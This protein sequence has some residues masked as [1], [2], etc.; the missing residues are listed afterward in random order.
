LHLV[1]KDG[2]FSISPSNEYSGLIS[3]T[4][5]WFDFVVH[6]FFGAQPSLWMRS[7]ILGGKALWI[8]V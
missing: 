8:D 5:Y 3:F 7:Y 6:S 1:E 4:I 2:S